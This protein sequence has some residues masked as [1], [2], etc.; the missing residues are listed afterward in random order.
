ME[1]KSL[2]LFFLIL[3]TVEEEEKIVG[4]GAIAAIATIWS[5]RL[6]A[7]VQYQASSFKFFG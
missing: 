2:D 4:K 5:G 7:L 6:V 3:R 1:A